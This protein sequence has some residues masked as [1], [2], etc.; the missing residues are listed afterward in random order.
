[1][2]SNT[3]TL[4]SPCSTT[5]LRAQ[6]FWAEMRSTS[7]L[8]QKST[9]ATTERLTKLESE[10]HDI[11]GKRIIKYPPVFRKLGIGL[12]TSYQDKKRLLGLDRPPQQEETSPNEIKFL[13][14]MVR[15]AHNA[16][17]GNWSWRII[18]EAEQKQQDGWYPF[19]VTLTV[20]PKKCNGR[21]LGNRPGYDTP[22]QLWKEGKEFRHY[23]RSL[24]KVVCKELGHPPPHKKPYRPESDYVTYAGVIEHGKSMEHHHAHIMVWMRE[25][26]SLWKIDPNQGRL[27]QNRTERECRPM[28][29]LWPW[30]IESQKPALYFRTKGDI[31]SRLG[32]ITPVDKDKRQPIK[33]LPVS[34]VGNYVTKYMQKGEKIWEH[35]MKCTRNLGMAKLQRLMDKLTLPQLEALS[36]R[37]QDSRQHHLANM[38]HSVPLGLV[39][40]AAI[41]KRFAILY[42]SRQ[43]DLKNLMKTNYDHYKLMLKSVKDGAR[44]DR[45]ASADFYDWVQKFLP[46]ET[47]YCEKRLLDSHRLLEHNFPRAIHQTQ[48]VVLGGNEIGFTRSI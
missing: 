7:H 19:F 23:I 33:M 21:P 2:S 45:M 26:P 1:M 25:I 36:W 15:N 18:Q 8:F 31:W 14:F 6:H 48:P 37:P 22:E 35:R 3:N 43:L 42:Q 5:P 38:T 30:C 20:D 40:C 27:P 9:F 17:K 10:L 13:Q 39:R 28:R 12:K 46:A 47:G 16:Q 4:S 34:A 11:L 44:P 29:T 32:H 24:A 41:R